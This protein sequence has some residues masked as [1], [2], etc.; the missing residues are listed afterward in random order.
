MFVQMRNVINE[1]QSHL[2]IKVSTSLDQ[3]FR[4]LFLKKLV[5]KI[6]PK[7]K[8]IVSQIFFLAL[9]FPDNLEAEVNSVKFC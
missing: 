1:T 2:D 5:T 8:F 7:I 4:R 6:K 3:R 9:E